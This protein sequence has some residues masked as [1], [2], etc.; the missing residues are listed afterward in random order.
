LRKF[1]RA[2][3]RFCLN[4]EA[5]QGRFYD[6]HRHNAQ[7][8]PGEKWGKLYVFA[9]YGM[10]EKLLIVTNFDHL[11]RYQFRLTLYYD[12][13]KRWELKPGKYR[14]IDQLNA[15]SVFFLFVEGDDAWVD[16]DIEKSGS[17]ILKL[18]N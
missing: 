9:R 15:K 16:I 4:S 6:L 11:N 18:D 7:L 14:L 1:Y 10:S 2:L 8:D 17:W 5:L 13:V 12:L 3:L